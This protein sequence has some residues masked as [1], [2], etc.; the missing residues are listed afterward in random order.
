[1]APCTY[2]LAKTCSAS[3][4][5]PMFTV[6]V[7]NEQNWNSSLPTVQQVIVDMGIFRVSLLKRQTHRV[8]VN[9]VWKKLPL[10][11]GSGTVN[12]KSNPAAV[13]LGTSFGLSV[14]FDNTGAVHVNLPSTYSDKVCGLCGNYNHVRGDDFRKPDGTTAQNATALAESWQSGQA[15]SS[16]ET[17]LLP[18]QCDPLEK[19]EYASE[20]YCGGL[21]S[22]TGPFAACQSV[23]GAESYFRGCVV[24]MC[25][26]HGDPAVLCEA[27]E[28]Y[29]DICQEAGISIPIWRNSTFCPLQCGE[30]SHYNSCADGCPE[31]CSSLDIVGSCGSCEERCECDSG[32]KLSGGKCVPAE[33]CGCWYNGNHYEKGATFSKGECEQ[34]CQCMGNNG[35]QCTSMQCADN[36]VCKVKGGV[37]GCFPFKPATCSVYGDPHYITFDGMAYDFQGGCSYTLTTTCS[38]ESPVQFTVIGHNMH[39]ALQNFTRSKLEAVALQ[40][41]DL[42]LTLNQ[43]GE[44]YVNNSPVRLP[45][46]TNGTYGSVRVYLKK[47]YIILETTFGLRLTIDARNRLFLQVDERYKYE[48]CGLCG[49]YS[50]RQDDDFIAP[51]GQN[52]TGPFEFGDSWK[53]PGNNDCISHPNDPRLCDYDEENDAYN[54]CYTLLGDDFKSCHELIHPNIYL[55]S[56]VFDY[57]ATNG[58]QHTLCE[59]LKSYAA[60]CQVAGVELPHW[61]T[62]TACADPP[63]TA[64]LPTR[65]TPPSTTSDQTLCPMNCDFETN[66]CGWEQLVQD[67]FDWK[68]HS[69]PTPSILTGPNQDHTTG[70]GFY[71]YIEGNNASHGDSSRLWSSM[72]HYNGPLC[73]NFWYHMYGSATA[74]ALNI[75]LLKDNEATKLWVMMNNQGPEWHAG[76]VDIEVS[77]PFQII[78]EGIRGSNNLSDVAIDDISIHFGSC[79][80]SFPGLISGTEP[81]S[82]TAE[83]LPSLPGCNIDCSFDSNLCSWNQM[84]TDAFDWTWHSGSTPTLMTGPSAGHTGDASGV[85]TTSPPKP[86]GNTTPPIVPEPTTAAPQPPVVNATAQLPDTAQ[87]PAANV[88]IPPTVEAQTD[89]ING[90]NVT[91][92]PD[93]RPPPHSVC[94]LNCNFEQ[95]LCQWN[96]LLTDVFD[97]TRYSGS[98]PTMMTGPSSDHTTGD[99]HYL[100]IEANSASNGDTARLISSECSDSGPQCLQFWYH[101]YGS[102]DTMGLHVYLFQ[103]RLAEAVWWRRNDHG[104]MWH[105]AQVDITTTEA[106]QIIVEGRRGSNEES[107]V[108]IDDVKLYRGRC[109]DESGVM[110]TGPPKPEGNTTPPIVPEPTT[111][112][113]QPP[114]VNATA[115]L[116]DTAQPPAAN[117][118]IPPTVEAQTDFINGDNVT[119][120]PDNR[121]PPH[122]VCQL[123]CNFEQGLCQWN[124]LLTDVFDWTRYSGSTPTMMTGPS[125]DHTTGDGHY[126][127]IEA[128][129]AS[130]GDTARLISSECSDSGP[131]CLQFWYHMY[132]SADTMG[133]HVYLF[134]DR[135]ADA[136]WWRR[137]DQGNMWHMAQVDIT[138]TEAFQIIVEGRRGSNEESDVAIDDVKLYRGRCSDESG[139]MTTGPP[140]PE[141]N[142]TPPIVPEP[143]T[144]APQPPVVN[145]TAQLPDTAQPPAANVT[146]P[147]TVE[148]QTDFINGDNVTEAPDNRPPPHSVCQLN[149]NFEQGLCQWNQLLT[150]VFDWTRYSGSTPTMMTGP[151]SDHTTGDGHYLYIEANSASNGDTARL[152]SSECSDS[153]PQ[154]LQFWYHMYGSADTMGLH[155]YLFKD[156]LAEAVWWRRNDHGNMWHMAQ[157]DIT[158]I[159]AFQIIFE[160]RIGSNDQ[161]DVAIDDKAMNLQLD[162]NHQQQLDHNLQLKLSQSYKPQLNH[163]HQP[164]LNHN[165]QPQLN[166]NPRQLPHSPQQQ[167]DHNLQQPINHIQQQVDL[168]PQQQLDH[169]LQQPINH[170]QQQVDLSLQQQLD[171]NLQ[172]PINHIQQQVDLSPQQQLDHNLQQ[173]INHIQQ[174]VDLNPQQQL[175]HNLQQPINHI[176][177]QVDLS[178]QQQLDHNLQQPINQIQ[179]QVDLSLQQQ[180]DHNLQQPINHIQQQV[181]LSPQQQLDHNLQQPINHIQQQV[182]LSL[183]QHLDHNLQEPINHIQQQVDL[184]LQ[185]QLDHNLQQPTNHIQQQVDLSPQQQLDHNLQQPI[186]HI[187]QQVDLSPQQQLDHNLQQPIN[188]IQQQV[189]L[190]PQQQ[191]D[192]NLQQP[193]NQ[194]QQQVD[195][196]PQQQ[197]DHN[198]QQPI[199]QIQQQVDLSLQQQLDHNLQQPINQIQQQVDLSPQQQLDHNLQQ[200]INQIQQQVDLSPQQQLDHNLQQPINHIQQQPTTTAGPQPTTTNKPHSTTG[201]P[202]P[203]TTARPQP[204]TTNKPHSTTGRPQPTTTAGP[205]STTTN[206]PHSTTGRPQPTTA[207]PQSTTARTQPPTTH[208]PTP[209]CPENCHYTACVPPCSPTC[210]HLNGPPGC[211]DNEGCVQGCVCDEGF[212]HGQRACVPI[213]QCGCVDSNGT[214]HHFNEVWYTNHCSQKCQCEKDD[215]VGEIDCDDEDEC[216]GDDVC[217]QNEKGNYYCQSTGFGEC[218]IRGDPEYRTFDQMKHEFDGEHSYV[219]VRTNNLPNYLP[220]VYIEAINTVHDDDDSQ[221]H[222]DSSSEEDHS[223]SARDEDDEDDDEDD[224]DDSK[225]DDDSEEHEEHHQLQEL[226]IRVYDHTVVFKKN[227]ML[228]VDG[229]KTKTPASPTAGLNIWK[230]SS[231]IYLKTDFGLSVEFNG[232][233]SAVIILPRLY[234]RKVGGLCGNFDGH[235]GNDWMKPDGTRARSIE[236]L[237]ESWIV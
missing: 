110:T 100:Y 18:H 96:Q 232:R 167:L 41:E 30:N 86:E 26:S 132:G 107:D 172:Q 208:V 108:A 226:K 196:S 218:T 40:V 138:T 198:L 89:F 72:C 154:C 115:Q 178:P 14:S 10:R 219:L 180:L 203:T 57:C 214:G 174:Q 125:S 106:F 5:M 233:S 25:S 116:P 159:G 47:N 173:P 55:N 101:M 190:S 151:S 75:Y 134:Q 64:T 202:Q 209:S 212:V 105:M 58:D 137:N 19:A 200:P 128:N 67:S 204:T 92:A 81:P 149:C 63:T 123:N 91:E 7:V 98:T 171:H 119:E 43:S 127:Y 189:D 215:G 11:L 206:K 52:A 146:I 69:G 79:S 139:V 99:G 51:G 121:P 187:Q 36:E 23:L 44:V 84:V 60:A 136:V 83:V 93:N 236:E 166:P 38:A 74:M 150:D 29:A 179:Q 223:R 70:A 126:L 130:N 33:D 211:S 45:Y 205:Q 65:P 207:T 157:V 133:L 82:T 12:I 28:V 76:I 229:R 90:D 114:V 176:Q 113:P 145:A 165:L 225:H 158:T 147:P 199:N 194:I 3:E 148:A 235:K 59:S 210:K 182:D 142:T 94:Q 112:A 230:H 104:N 162:H 122:S 177:Q 153:G 71:M 53:V 73:L 32:L 129:S 156:R 143:T 85:V 160:G 77:G 9:G 168:S 97:W 20:L 80:G 181:D 22:S 191:L 140:K 13:E 217:L 120:A 2:T 56:C 144:A 27:L 35:M 141:G 95:G 224:D 39:S 1:M 195:L 16:C 192:H 111:A 6:E 62:N 102:A 17:I 21:L 4:A 164:Q 54:E 37:K 135:L 213:Q 222:G 183:Q 131:Q 216:D 161:S 185:Q 231:R 42:Y 193:I 155:V 61:Q 88:T 124:Q 237:G 15:T 66:L 50:E 68:R 170:I 109:S 175:D 197:L 103:D 24:G 220:Y 8:V 227:R 184:S 78:V 234:K 201:R 34:R 221:H 188:H 228:V 46:S 48:L 31:V 169:N 49:T 152:I 163:N 117:V 186:N 87:P 118:T